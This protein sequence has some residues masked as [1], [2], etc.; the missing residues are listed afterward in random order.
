MGNM[1]LHKLAYLSFEKEKKTKTNKENETN[2]M[3]LRN[4]KTQIETL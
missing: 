4:Q 3:K 1:N 2:E